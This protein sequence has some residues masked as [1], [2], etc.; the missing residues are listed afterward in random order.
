MGSKNHLL[1]LPAGKLFA[2]PR[3]LPTGAFLCGVRMERFLSSPLERSR[4]TLLPTRD[5]GAREKQNTFTEG[6][7]HVTQEPSEMKTKRLQENIS[8]LRCTH[9]A[10]ERNLHSDCH[11]Q[12]RPSLA[13]PC[14]LPNL[15]CKCFKTF[16]VISFNLSSSSAWSDIDGFGLAVRSEQ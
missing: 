12:E 15:F 14:N 7:F 3:T 11:W 13:C 9:Q 2:N 8:H 10:W 1:W 5:R 16:Q 4:Q 6:N